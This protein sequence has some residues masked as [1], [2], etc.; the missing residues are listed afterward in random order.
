MQCIWFQRIRENQHC[1][2]RF[3]QKKN[4]DYGIWVLDDALHFGKRDTKGVRCLFRVPAKKREALDSLIK[5]C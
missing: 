4:R 2:V 3:L 1:P 5:E